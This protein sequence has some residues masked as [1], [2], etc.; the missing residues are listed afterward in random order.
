MEVEWLKKRKK[1]EIIIEQ[2][3]TMKEL[4]K[5]KKDYSSRCRSYKIKTRLVKLRNTF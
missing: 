1:I 4:L 3:G 2:W 5:D